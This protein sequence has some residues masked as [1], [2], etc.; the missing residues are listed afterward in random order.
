MSQATIEGTATW[1]NDII[2]PHHFAGLEIT[3]PRES[4]PTVNMLIYG[5]S[6]VGKTLLAASADAV[7]DMR[8]VLVV[9]MEG[10]QLTLHKTRYQ[11]DIIRVTKWTQLEAIWHTL[12]AGSHDYKTVV[13]DSLSEA[14]DASLANITTER[15]G[16]LDNFELDAEIPQLQ[17]YG[18][19]MVRILSM[20]RKFR[21]LPMNVIFTALTRDEKD[22]KT[23]VVRKLPDLTGKLAGK[24]P[25]IFDNVLYYYTKEV[26][27]ETRRMLLTSKTSNTVA[28][29]RGDDRLPQVIEV[30][31][32]KE[33]ATM[34]IVFNGILGRE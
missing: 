2:T 4:S 34:E 11:P 18:K 25:A 14:N 33:A 7:P 32:F 13:V 30:P 20:L 1:S 5:E 9:D 27:G 31:D 28:K 6:G 21:D 17:E 15:A 8:K 22:G 29:N 3:K 12:Y 23:G 26:D 19:N 24:V 10:G 16:N